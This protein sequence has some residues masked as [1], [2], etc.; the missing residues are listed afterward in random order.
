MVSDDSTNELIYW[1]DSG[2]SF[3]SECM[4][5]QLKRVLS[6]CFAKFGSAD[7]KL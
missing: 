4:L 5:C 2:D 6:F 1:A 3:M 7:G